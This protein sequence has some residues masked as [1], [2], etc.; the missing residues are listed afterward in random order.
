MP[1]MA[2]DDETKHR[3]LE[4]Q[5]SASSR[6]S[7]SCMPTATDCHGLPRIATNCAWLRLIATGRP[8]MTSDCR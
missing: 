7:R 3:L 5:V 1:L 2:S 6:P 4:E 8:L